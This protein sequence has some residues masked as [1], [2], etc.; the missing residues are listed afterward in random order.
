MSDLLREV[1]EAVRAD[2]MKRLWD[3][4]K[5]AIITAITAL[6]LGTAAFSIWKNMELKQ[7]RAATSQ[8]LVS[9]ESD[10]SAAALKETAAQ[11]NGNAQAIAYLNA[12]SMEL[13]AGNRNQAL[14]AFIAAEKAAKADKTLRDLAVLQKTSLIMDLKPETP[15]AEILKSL[16]LITKDKSSPFQAEALFL[17]A[18]VKGEKDKNYSQAVKDLETL[19]AR[20]DVPGS[21]K[22]RAQALQ[23]VYELKQVK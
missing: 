8:I 15:A 17:S 18:F 10:K 14:E 2:N 22:Q 19:E 7:N 11:L 1:D 23:S 4:H 6:I 16:E 21:L 9:L 13:K 20:A 12:G 3:E 5:I